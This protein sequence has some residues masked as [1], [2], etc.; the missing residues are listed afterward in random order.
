MSGTQQKEEG[1]SERETLLQQPWPYNRDLLRGN[2]DEQKGRFQEALLAYDRLLEQNSENILVQM[3]KAGT[4]RWLR[5]FEEA[6]TAALQALALAE[7]ALNNDSENIS[8]YL[9]KGDILFSI[10]SE[11]TD[12]KDCDAAALQAY[13]Q[14]I[15]LDPSNTDAYLN[16]GWLLS[17]LDRFRGAMQAYEQAL[18]LEPNNPY[19]HACIGNVYWETGRFEQALQAQERSIEL[20]P[21]EPTYYGDKATILT[22][23]GRAGEARQAEAQ[24]RTLMEQQGRVEIDYPAEGFLSPKAQEVRD[25][26]FREFQ[27]RWLRRQKEAWEKG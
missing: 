20:D 23:L 7:R 18:L 2:E 27:E 14:A 10:D 22:Q 9:Y 11:Y 8:A 24:Y 25:Q 13:E 26:E 1:W 19:I 15:L 5:R 21:T 3:L 6:T 4:L 17:T 12:L 16:K